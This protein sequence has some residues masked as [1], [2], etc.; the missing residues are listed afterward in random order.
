ML[1]LSMDAGLEFIDALERIV[2]TWP[3]HS[4]P[5][6]EE[7]TDMIE[8]L[9]YNKPKDEVF[10]GVR[11]RAQAGPISTLMTAII[12][13]G[14][15]GTSL[16]NILR[17]QAATMRSQRSQIAQKMANEAPVKILFPLLFI[18]TAVALTLFSSILIKLYYGQL[19]L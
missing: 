18:F 11:Q 9:R 13:A 15:T 2:R 8:E 19:F 14:K 7:F 10:E 4:E 12:Q 16:V 5:L 17:I 6:I 1:T 3:R